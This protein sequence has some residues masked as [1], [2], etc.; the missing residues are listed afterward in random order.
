MSAN[1]TLESFAYRTRGESAAISDIAQAFKLICR[2]IEHCA[3]SCDDYCGTETPPN[4]AFHPTPV[5]AMMC[6]RG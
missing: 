3:A 1:S 6:R 4:T 5:G 2:A